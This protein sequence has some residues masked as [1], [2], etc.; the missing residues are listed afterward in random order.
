M[1]EFLWALKLQ[2]QT[3]MDQLIVSV[4]PELR[5]LAGRYMRRER[6]SHT[7]Q[8]TALLNEAYLKLSDNGANEWE[9]RTH[10]M[11]A[12]A[13]AMRRI[14]VDHARARGAG[15]RGGAAAKLALDEALAYSPQESTQISEL[16][17]ALERLEKVD[18][19]K[20]R[21]VEMRFFGGM[22]IEETAEALQISERTVKRYWSAARARLYKDMSERRSNA[23]DGTA[24]GRR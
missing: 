1:P 20:A 14:L 23:S 24:P 11:A 17:E 6:G 10:F 3:R 12:A 2:T 22:S 19:L 21:I 9:N 15:K 13:Q 8:P 16:N 7:L 5:R 18:P 4:Y